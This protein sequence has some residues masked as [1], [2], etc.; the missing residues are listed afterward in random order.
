MNEDNQH[1]NKDIRAVYVVADMACSHDGKL[2]LAKQIIDGVGR[3]GASA[4]Q[5]QIWELQHIMV[6]YHPQYD[7][8]AQ[9][10]FPYDSWRELAA[11]TRDRF[12]HL[13]II[14][15]VYE[16]ISVDFC[17][18]IDVDAY[19][20]HAADL[21]NRGLIKYIASTGKRIDLSVG[22]STLDEITKAIDWLKCTSESNIWL[23]YGM[24][25]FPTPVEA[26]NLSFLL[27]LRQL[28]QLPVGYQDHSDGDSDSAFWLPAAAIGMGINILEK[29]ITHDRSKKGVDHEAALNPDEFKR[30]VDMV[31]TIESAMGSSIPRPFTS[32]E[33]KYRKYSKKSLV[34][35]RDLVSGMVLKDGDLLYMRAEEL[36]LPPDQADRLIGRQIRCDIGAYQLVLES[37]LL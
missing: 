35:A 11:Y 37:D 3:S 34:A 29:H 21:S 36:G 31:R 27:S 17:E 14:G 33:M 12:P 26:A 2:R 19:K 15:C 9:V 16:P 22:A 8:V 5:F 13:K 23:M 7:F 28:F 25:N 24:Q 6:P 4:I 30:F 20:V 10:E 32:D 18:E 1:Y